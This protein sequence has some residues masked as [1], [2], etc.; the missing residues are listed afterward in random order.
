LSLAIEPTRGVL[1]AKG[2]AVTR[3]AHLVGSLPAEDTDDAMRLALNELGPRLR[4]LPDGETGERR[5]WIIH[6]IDALRRHPD[7]ELKKDGDWSDY[8]KT[9]VLRMRRG[10]HIAGCQPGLRA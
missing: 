6:I 1:K 8:D 2:A 5:N 7:L 3:S 9:P 10:P 4:W